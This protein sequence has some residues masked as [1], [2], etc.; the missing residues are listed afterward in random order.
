MLIVLTGI[1]MFILGYAAARI[2]LHRMQE[3]ALALAE[4]C[5]KEMRK[6]KAIQADRSRQDEDKDR[7]R[8]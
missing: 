4:A 1:V 2:R 3:H 6:A 7:P 8:G 5:L